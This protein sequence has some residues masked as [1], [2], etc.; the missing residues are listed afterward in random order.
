M[1]QLQNKQEVKKQYRTS[2]NLET[3]ISIHDKYSINQ[4]GFGPWILSQYEIKEQSN[5]LE[6][7]C[8]T[9]IMWRHHLDLLKED[10]KLILSDF[11]A[12]MVEKAKNNLGQT[13][14]ISYEKIDIQN[15]PY[16]DHSFDI[17]IANMMLYH[18]PNL[19]QA[20]AEVK[21]VLKT[22]GHFY[23]AT[24]G[25]NGIIE[26]V[27]DLAHVIHQTNKVFTLQNGQ[28]I[29]E[30]YF[31]NVKRLD[32]KDALAITNID[33]LLDYIYSLSSMTHLSEMNREDLKKILE[34]KM[35]NDL[36]MIPKEYGMFVS[37]DKK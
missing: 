21:R 1:G 29:L 7:G 26:Y 24:Y 32:Y 18:V 15:I 10:S 17:V 11:S 2:Q 8:G 36:L 35:D 16:K 22:D 5:I 27:E 31:S 13:E 20:L 23:C 28:S 34:T 14:Q 30:K 3:R 4:Q 6:L 33:D 25:E 19:N 9:G 12:G 37:N